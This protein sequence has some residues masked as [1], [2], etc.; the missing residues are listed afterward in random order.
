MLKC[1]KISKF[2]C[3]NETDGNDADYKLRSQMIPCFLQ[4]EPSQRL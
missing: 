1:L 3:D 2:S 4:K